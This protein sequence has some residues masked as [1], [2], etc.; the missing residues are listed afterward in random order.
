MTDWAE[1]RPTIELVK[2]TVTVPEVAEL[3]GLE[4][5]SQN[6]I[7]S[8]DNPDERT[9]SLHLYEDHW[10]DFAAGKGG[11]V[12]DLVQAA[13][14]GTTVEQAVR[15][16]WTRALKAGKEPGDVERE[17]VRQVVD[18]TGTLEYA[19]PVVPVTFEATWEARLG[20]RPPRG[21]RG[22]AD[23]LWIPHRDLEGTYGVKVRRADGS[24]DALTG[25]QFT[26]RLYDPDGW[27]PRRFSWAQCIVAEGESDCWALSGV[28]RWTA[29]VLALPSG[30]QSWKDSWLTDLEPF[31]KVWICTDNDRAG[32]QARE[33]LTGKIGYLKA[34]QLRVPPLYNDAR[35]A[36][37]AGWK[38]QL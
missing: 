11:D 15:Q 28:F 34:E 12:I 5:N 13:H 35:E 29:P 9:P 20:V 16:L 33:K 19:F 7:A 14:P 31:E 22:S 24:K 23:E 3:L 25:S 10:W 27:R 4:P 8:F 21:C 6:K 36:I 32:E 18:F 2:Q 30:A 17:P 1:Q 37:A 38:P 26:K